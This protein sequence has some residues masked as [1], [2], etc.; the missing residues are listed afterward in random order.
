MTRL[1]C[2]SASG[3]VR[4]HMPTSSPTVPC[5]STGKTPKRL[6]AETLSLIGALS[7][8]KILFQTL[9]NIGGFSSVRHSH[10]E[11]HS[12]ATCREDLDSFQANDGF[13]IGLM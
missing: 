2:C 13:N 3:N 1:R 9:A 5:R 12:I 8:I 10:R 6:R 11:V 7:I 4:C